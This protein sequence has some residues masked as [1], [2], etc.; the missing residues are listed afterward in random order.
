MPTVAPAL[1]KS[2]RHMGH[3]F[4]IWDPL[5]ALNHTNLSADPQLL[6]NDSATGWVQAPALHPNGELCRCAAGRSWLWSH[7]TF[8][9]LTNYPSR[10][11]VFVEPTELAARGTSIS[12]VEK[13][14]RQPLKQALLPHHN[15]V[16]VK[17]VSTSAVYDVSVQQEGAA[18]RCVHRLAGGVASVSVGARRL[19]RRELELRFGDQYVLVLGA[20]LGR[21]VLRQVVAAGELSVLWMVPQ[22]ALLSVSEIMFYMSGG[23][24]ASSQAVPS[25]R[26]T[27]HAL[28]LF[29]VPAALAARLSGDQMHCV[30]V[31]PG[32]L[33]CMFLLTLPVFQDATTL[34]F[35]SATIML[36]S[37]F[38]FVLF[39]RKYTYVDR[40]KYPISKSSKL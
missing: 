27:V 38:V 24:F 40:S 37:V 10:L 31:V 9:T 32:N 6:A 14:S 29:Q 17:H 34:L 2:S 3:M 4:V 7:A 15:T 21:S 12:M 26:S 13:D 36:A 25:M 18:E 5:T 39:A 20:E 22:Y 11:H 16:E 28:W 1:D 30:Q 35:S 33:L 19:L 8:S 23:E